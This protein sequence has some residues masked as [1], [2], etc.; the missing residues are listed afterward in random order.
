MTRLL[1]LLPL[2]LAGCRYPSMEE[3]REACQSW[4][5]DGTE[6][7]EYCKS[8]V[9]RSEPCITKAEREKILDERRKNTKPGDLIDMIGI[10]PLSITQLR[11][12]RK[13]RLEHETKQY[14]GIEGGKGVIRR[15]RYWLATVVLV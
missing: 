12:R 9:M 4:A 3:A 7:V 11:Q 1:L 5:Y 8:Y 6:L 13:C 10:P 14:E 15:F 2:L